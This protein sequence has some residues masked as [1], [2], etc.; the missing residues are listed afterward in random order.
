MQWELISR[1]SNQLVTSPALRFLYWNRDVVDCTPRLTVPFSNHPT[2]Q[3][4]RSMFSLGKHARSRPL[5]RDLQV[6][7]DT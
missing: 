6:P 5:R 3:R 4:L 7:L 2:N 1:D